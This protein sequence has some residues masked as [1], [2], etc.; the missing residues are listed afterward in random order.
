MGE[1]QKQH[2]DD[3]VKVPKEAVKDLELPTDEA[4]NVKGGAVDMFLKL[5][6]G[7]LYVKGDYSSLNFSTPQLNTSIKY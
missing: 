2:S 1:E 7:D 6:G 3:W 5:S 4:G